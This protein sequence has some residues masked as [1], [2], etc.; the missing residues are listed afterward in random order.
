M[1]VRGK[2]TN[3]DNINLLNLTL[4]EEKKFNKPYIAIE[5]VAKRYK[6]N[7]KK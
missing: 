6:N 7:K 5:W 2:I 3:T 4:N 1:K